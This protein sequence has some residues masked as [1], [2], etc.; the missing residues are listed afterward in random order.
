MAGSGTEPTFVLNGRA[1]EV[2]D[3]ARK[4]LWRWAKQPGEVCPA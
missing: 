2:I 1:V 4:N 3:L